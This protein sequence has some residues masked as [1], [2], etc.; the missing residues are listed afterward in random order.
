MWVLVGSKH[1]MAPHSTHTCM[2][3]DST[4]QEATLRHYFI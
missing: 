1:C 4:R 2:D 3:R